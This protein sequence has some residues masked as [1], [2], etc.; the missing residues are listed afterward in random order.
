MKAIRRF[1]AVLMA[2]AAVM[3]SAFAAVAQTDTT[4]VSIPGSYWYDMAFD[5]LEMVNSQRQAQGLSA[6][7]MDEDLMEGAMLRAAE[8][9]LLFSHTRPD[10]TRC[11]T[12]SNKAMGE[13]IAAGSSTAEGTMNQWMNSQG[14]RENILNTRWSSMGVGCFETNGRYYWVQLF[15]EQTAA[16]AAQPQNRTLKQP[17]NTLLDNLEPYGS[18][19][20]GELKT[21]Q[22]ATVRFGW[23]NQGWQGQYALASASD[24]TYVSSDT[25]IILP[26]G[27]GNLRAVG[28]GTATGTVSLKG[29]PEK[30]LTFTLKVE[31]EASGTLPGDVDRNGRV[32]SADALMALQA[33][34]GKVTLD[35]LQQQAADVNNQSGVSAGDALLILQAATG[36]ITLS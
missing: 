22:T 12:V 7:T 30:S 28:P 16:Q 24:L 4:T 20:S 19:S 15:G 36:K 13:N 17:V 27:A 5:V 26:D 3:C 32:E 9:S 18:L 6:L 23:R 2:V 21:G 8:T 11:F 29:Y 31:G 14:H 35:S 33:A 34:T 25:G 10:G 1:T